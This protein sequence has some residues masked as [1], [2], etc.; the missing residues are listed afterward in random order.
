M[1]ILGLSG[2]AHDAAACL[3]VDG[4]VVSAIEEERVTRQKNVWSFPYRSIDEVLAMTDM[5]RDQIDAV[6]FYWDDRGSLLPAIFNELKQF[7]NAKIPTIARITNRVRAAWL[8]NDIKKIILKLFEFHNKTVPIYFS[9]H[10]LCHVAYSFFCSNFESSA[11]LIIDGRGEFSTITAFDC[12]ENQFSKLYQINMPH[13]LGYVYAAITQYLGFNPLSDE[14]YIMGLASYGKSIPEID[15]FFESFIQIKAPHKLC[16]NM[17]YCNYQYNEQLNKTWLSIKAINLLNSF[18]SSSEDMMSHSANIALSLQKRIEHVV[19]VLVNSVYALTRHNNLVLGGGVAMNSVCNK[20]IA[21]Q[22]NFKNVFVP[23]APSDQGC[24]IGAALY[25]SRKLGDGLK[26]T[27][28]NPYLG[29]IYNDEQIEVTLNKFKLSYSKSNDIS[30]LVAKEIAEGKICGYFQGNM[31]FGARAL[32]NRSILGDPRDSEMRNKINEAIKFREKF[33]PFAATILNEHIGEYSE[34]PIYSPYMG[35]VSKVKK[36]KQILIPAVTHVDETCRFQTLKR[37][38]NSPYYDVI[39]AFYSLTG[40]PLILNTSFNIK[41]EP[42]VMNPADAIRCFYST[43]L[44]VLIL[45][46]FIIRK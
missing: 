13:S 37:V 8:Q 35:F 22:S 14:Y 25:I 32:G 44:D 10:H 41:G 19:L 17:E 15:L 1:V 43:G 5:K 29:P 40:I 3:V 2:M 20:V 18:R 9:N 21:D 24:A 45:G 38:D 30:S 11:G 46:N 33:R 6:S 39:C 28:N 12:L 42:I 16:I 31:E 7:T 34:N 26:T 4:Q 27:A 36:E 23:P